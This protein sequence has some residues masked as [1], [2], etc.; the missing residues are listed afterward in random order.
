LSLHACCQ[1]DLLGFGIEP[2]HCIDDA[3]ISRLA[4]K[5]YAGKASPTRKSCGCDF[6]VDL[7]A[8]DT[9][10]HLCWYCYANSHPAPVGRNFSA[11]RIKGEFLVE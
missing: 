2:A 9:C 11:H 1:P 5:N 3:L 8:Y 7:G 6:S 4:H 10:P